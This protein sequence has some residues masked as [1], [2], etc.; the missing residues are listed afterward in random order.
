MDDS[1]DWESFLCFVER[2]V[3]NLTK[4]RLP[5]YVRYSWGEK[6]E[7]SNLCDLLGCSNTFSIVHHSVANRA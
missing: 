6:F 2:Y 1:T 7:G 4:R 5:I 3:V